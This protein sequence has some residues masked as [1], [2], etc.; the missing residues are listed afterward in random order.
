MKLKPFLRQ[1][2]AKYAD[3]QGEL[4][5][6]LSREDIMQDMPQFLALSREHTDVAAVASRWQRYGQR[7]SDLD[8]AR[9]MQT[10]AAG[11][12]EKGAVRAS[13]GVRP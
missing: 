1:Q 9:A 4:E 13:A 2:L 5:F 12:A 11:D 3:R 6:L 8:A 10:E 7:E